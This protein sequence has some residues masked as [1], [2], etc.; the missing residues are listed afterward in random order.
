MLPNPNPAVVCKAVSGGA[1][2]LD[3]EQEVYFGLNEVGRQVWELLP[4]VCGSV[5]EICRRISEVYPDVD[6]Q[7]IERDVADLLSSL[8]QEGLVIGG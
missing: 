4:P 3:T 7:E 1:V 2:L 5:E 8:S 6:L